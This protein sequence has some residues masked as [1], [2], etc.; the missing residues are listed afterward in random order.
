MAAI[1]FWCAI[2]AIAYVYIGYPALIFLLARLRPR[3]VLP[4]P[5]LPTVSF[6]IAAYNEETSITAKLDNTLALDYPRERLEIMVVSDGSTDGMEDLV[7][8]RFGGRVKLLALRGRRGKTL[9]QNAA[10]AAATG[11]IIVFSD[12]T[13]VY[14]PPCLRALVSRFADPA[15]GCVTGS[16]TY[17]TE[18]AAAVDRGRS[19]YW[20][21]ESFLRWHESVFASVLGAAGCCYAVRR[22]LYTPLEADVISDVAQV[23][24][25]LDQGRRAVVAEDAVVFEPPESGTIGD[26]LQRRARVITRG[27]RVKFRLRRFFLRHPWFLLQVLSHRV[28]RWAVPI[29]LIVAF[30][31][32]LFLLDRGLYRL[33]FAGQLALYATAALAYLLERRRVHVPGLVIPL[34]FCVVNLAPLLALRALV[35]GDK[36]VTWETGRSATV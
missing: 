15:V 19:T 34:Y 18:G 7:R 14:H 5:S 17:G 36:Q 20:G 3:P 11:E 25:V 27:L 32:N 16:V 33:L 23:I 9:A 8:T 1:V 21:Y 30:V 22:A 28:L 4:G 35:R 13:T 12:A 26:E 29:F 31:A 10:V 2:G 6:I 24:H